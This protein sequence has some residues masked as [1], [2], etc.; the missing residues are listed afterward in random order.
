MNFSFEENDK[1]TPKFKIILGI[2]LFPCNPLMLLR[3]TVRY[4]LICIYQP[5]CG[6]IMR[7]NFFIIFQLR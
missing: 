3:S 2:H 7:T 6:G 1:I 5:I 4:L